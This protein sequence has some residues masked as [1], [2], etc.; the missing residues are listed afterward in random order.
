V[1]NQFLR[2]TLIDNAD[3]RWEFFPRAG[4]LFAV[5]GFYKYFDQPIVEI[6]TAGDVNT[7]GAICTIKNGDYARVRGAEVELQRALDFLPGALKHFAIGGNFTR[8]LSSIH[9]ADS[10]GLSAR[11]FVG[12]SPWVVN[13]NLSY[14]VGTSFSFSVLYNYFADR[15]TNYSNLAR[16]NSD[17]S[18]SAVPN[19]NWVERG[20]SVLDAKVRFG[21]SKRLKLSLSAKNL[22]RSPVVVAEDSGQMN[23]VNRYNPGIT[24]SS[25][26][27]YD[28]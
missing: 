22:T 17:Q 9:F 1:G 25:T 13:A 18:V 7:A 3:A 26:F 20:R 4:D 23:L 15:I 2:R 11:A 27:T 8:V 6:R 12:Q 28:F 10:L 19:P 24:V 16:Q 21:F 5:S 14:D